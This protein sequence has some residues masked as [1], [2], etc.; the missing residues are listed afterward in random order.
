MFKTLFQS[1]PRV[2]PMECAHRVR[3]GEAFLVDVREPGE[4]AEG[5]ARSARLLAFSDLQNGRAQWK[6]FLQEVGN[7]EILLYCAS[8][9]RSGLAARLLAAEGFRVANTGGFADW[10]AAG[11]PVVKPPRR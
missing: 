8:G 6:P 7:R 1:V 5:V 4:W 2:P 9:T 11:W 3:A 10:A